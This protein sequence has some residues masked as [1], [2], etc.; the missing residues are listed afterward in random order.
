MTYL[1]IPA[2]S[3]QQQQQEADA[4]DTQGL[5]LT[6]ALSRQTSTRNTGDERLQQAVLEIGNSVYGNPADGDASQQASEEGEKSQ[7][8]EK[9]EDEKKKEDK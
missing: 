4:S 9:A 7:E 8:G 3:L 5:P 6:H 2:K 1:F